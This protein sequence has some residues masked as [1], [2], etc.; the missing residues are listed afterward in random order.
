[1]ELKQKI[2]GLKKKTHLDKFFRV[3]DFVGF[4]I[5]YK[6]ECVWRFFQVGLGLIQS[7]NISVSK[8][9]YNINILCGQ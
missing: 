6:L 2:V 5:V 9:L 1:M 7:N 8:C 4:V 3:D